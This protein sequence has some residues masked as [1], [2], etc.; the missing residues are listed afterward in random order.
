M[1][2]KKL[3]IV[4]EGDSLTA[5]EGASAGND[6]PAQL[7]TLLGEPI[8]LTNFAVGGS[9]LTNELAARAGD[10]DAALV[11]DAW[12]LNVCLPWAGTNDMKA[13]GLTGADT[14]DLY[15]AYCQARQSAGYK[16]V[17][18]TVLPRS[19]ATVP[20]GFETERQAFNALVRANWATFADALA[21][22]A[23]DYRIGDAGDEWGSV[24]F[25]DGVH[26]TDRGYALIARMA[27]FAV[28]GLARTAPMDAFSKYASLARTL[29]GATCELELRTE[30]TK[31]D[32][33]T[34]EVT[35]VR[36][37]VCK[38]ITRKRNSTVMQFADVD[39]AA[40]DRIFPFET[41]TV[42]DWPNLYVGHV[43][44]RVPQGVGTARKVPL[45][46][47]DTNGSSTWT[48][49]AT[50]LLGA[51]PVTVL[52]VY[53]GSQPGQGAIV[54][55]SEYTVSTA[56]APSGY[57][58][59]TIVFSRE[60]IDFQGRPYVLEADLTL[61]GSRTPS[62]EVKRMLEAFDLPTDAAAFTQA[63]SNDNV[64]GYFVD[65]LYGGNGRTGRA[66]LGDLCAAARGWLARSSS[67]DWSIVQDVAR[68]SSAEFDSSGDLIRI[69]EY[70]D[71]EIPASVTMFYR[72]RAGLGEDWSE[73]IVRETN[74]A[75]GERRMHNPYIYEHGVADRLACYWQRRLN[76]QLGPD[77]GV[78]KGTI[79]AAQIANG[80]RITIVDQV[81]WTGPKDF[82][83]LGISRPA[84][85]NNLTLQCYDEDV[86]TYVAG[87]VPSDA[88]NDYSPDYAFTPPA[89]PTGLQ[90]VSQGTS[91]DNDGKVTAYALIRAVPPAVNWSRLMVQVTDTTTNEIYQA[92]LRL[93]S[94]N[95]EAVVGGLRPNRAHNVVAW[96]VNA[97]NIDGTSTS[98]VN[99][100][101]AN[102][103]TA[104]AAP[105][106]SVTQIQSREVKVALG[107]VAD[108][109]GQPKHRRNILF[110]KVG[111]GA[112]T[113]VARSEER[114]FIRTVTH[115]TAYEYKARSEDLVGNE[116]VD[117]STVSI[118]PAA[119]ID[120]GYIIGQ[121]VSG[122][123]IANSSINQGRT[124]STTASQS[125]N[126]AS[127]AVV[128]VGGGS[129]S[130][131]SFA[132]GLH[133]GNSGSAIGTIGLLITPASTQFIYYIKNNDAST[134][135]YEAA[136]RQVSTT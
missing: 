5:G 40:L 121:G 35:N 72:P 115:G 62:D 100:T 27:D 119:K 3:N 20:A 75:S 61:P 80:A 96:A 84:D 131:Y 102:A 43:G 133:V 108:V 97:N 71:G 63:I 76:A 134:Q 22:V 23:A 60:Q 88:T 68:S 50:K 2:T 6:W 113:E 17:A 89:A 28:C 93:V 14:Y 67:G 95:Y 118:T 30:L 64:A 29:R 132:P 46:W 58:V 18:F 78:A 136:W 112:F 91:A 44:Q 54:D 13:L 128:S 31:A 73:P 66:I 99:F 129:S 59:V 19:G 53:R 65:P 92:Q 85:A 48:Y 77:G 104:L 106:P 86:Y 26:M 82:I 110:E 135:P 51:A 90:V 36:R 107:A 12:T 74:G 120:D 37:A 116:S 70:G 103:T 81:H 56:T 47:I 1:R 123:S 83:A 57:S 15:L 41:F 24:Y 10:V 21:D 117:S 114:T 127:G 126:V 79:Y 32:G 8:T 125:G 42:A 111:A 52:T 94:G 105:T 33:T 124:S 109:A 98:A 87:T 69:D 16:V 11:Q 9:T 39:L 38:K 122:T 34:L 25:S 101:S 7:E 55:P 45:T 49:A 130:A 4:T